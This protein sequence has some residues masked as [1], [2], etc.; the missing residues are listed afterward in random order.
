MSKLGD[1]RIAVIG[2]LS[3]LFF[4][5]DNEFFP[6]YCSVTLYFGSKCQITTGTLRFFGLPE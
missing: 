6:L 5:A 1:T 3:F 2:W 4:N